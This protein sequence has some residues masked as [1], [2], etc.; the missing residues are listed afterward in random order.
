MFTDVKLRVVDSRTYLYP[1]II[2]LCIKSLQLSDSIKAF[3]PNSNR[4]Q[5]R[6]LF[7]HSNLNQS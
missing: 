1:I 3:N 4:C 2:I 7:P 6:I 5:L